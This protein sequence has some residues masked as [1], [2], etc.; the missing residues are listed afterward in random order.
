MCD[1]WSGP[2]GTPQDTLQD[3][4]CAGI[5][6]LRPQVAHLAPDRV[7]SAQARVLR[8][9]LY[10]RHCS[11][12]TIVWSARW[13]SATPAGMCDGGEF[14][15]GTA[16]THQAETEISNI[17]LASSVIRRVFR[18]KPCYHEG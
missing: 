14:R 1:S 17:S 18:D 9:L 15:L 7:R 5:R 4:M 13:F 16:Q 10:V 11:V 3:R 8:C 6:P 12:P 2:Y